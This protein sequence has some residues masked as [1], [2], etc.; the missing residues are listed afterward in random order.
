MKQLKKL[1]LEEQKERDGIL[2]TWYNTPDTGYIIT[3]SGTLTPV[4]RNDFDTL[5]SIREQDIL[6]DGVG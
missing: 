2:A 1:T 4:Y 6:V 3:A 5:C